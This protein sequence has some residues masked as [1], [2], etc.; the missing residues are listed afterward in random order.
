MGQLSQLNLQ[1]AFMC[2]GTLRKDIQNQS[3]SCEHP[4]AEDL[5]QV[6]L[7]TRAKR[8]IKNYQL[9]LMLSAGTRNLLKLSLS[10]KRAGVRGAP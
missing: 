5:L 3:C 6:A 2:A 4:A 10:D 9:G 8:M 1:L 7:L